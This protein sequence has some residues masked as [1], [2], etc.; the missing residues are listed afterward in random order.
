MIDIGE[1][2]VPKKAEKQAI[3]WCGL[4]PQLNSARFHSIA[5]PS[6]G[7]LYRD[8]YSAATR[9]NPP[10]TKEKKLFSRVARE[11]VHFNLRVIF[12][13]SMKECGET[14][15]EY[16][17]SS[18]RGYESKIDVKH[19]NYKCEFEEDPSKFYWGVNHGL[20]TDE[21]DASLFRARSIAML[22]AV[23]N[24]NTQKRIREGLELSTDF[25]M[26]NL[27]EVS[28][29]GKLEFLEQYATWLSMIDPEYVHMIPVNA[30]I[31]RKTGYNQYSLFHPPDLITNNSKMYHIARQ[32]WCELGEEKK[33][34]HLESFV[35]S[36][37]L[38]IVEPLF[39]LLC[40]MFNWKHGLAESLICNNDRLVE[41]HAS[42][43]IDAISRDSKGLFFDNYGHL[44]LLCGL[45]A[46]KSRIEYG[47]REV[48]VAHI[49]QHGWLLLRK[50]FL[51]IVLFDFV[52][53]VKEIHSL[54]VMR[55]L[56]RSKEKKVFVRREK[57]K[58]HFDP[59]FEHRILP[60]SRM[61]E[62]N[63]IIY[64]SQ[65]GAVDLFAP[66][67]SCQVK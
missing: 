61:N 25:T 20:F 5:I 17:G 39:P 3:Y 34:A 62:L 8:F 63:D 22:Q 59:E 66:W 58:S 67:R 9:F 36:F 53:M 46:P 60:I 23:T 24:E 21:R 12:N 7:E 29:S 44:Q 18:T 1:L 45:D 47:R 65:T 57:P 50:A 48:F 11:K 30:G 41:V 35:T 43:M 2:E 28:R 13:R 33:R 51:D 40:F 55:S 19:G 31:M 38:E 10:T 14:K 32:A 52:H 15:F 6:G 37:K 64:G 26:D 54:Q 4:R 16:K 49:V 56:T 27:V 42:S